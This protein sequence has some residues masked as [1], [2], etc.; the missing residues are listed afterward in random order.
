MRIVRTGSSSPLEDARAVLVDQ[1][2]VMGPKRVNV[3]EALAL[4]VQVRDLELNQPLAQGQILDNMLLSGQSE[5][6]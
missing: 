2:L 3:R 4:A 6:A 5:H 1:P